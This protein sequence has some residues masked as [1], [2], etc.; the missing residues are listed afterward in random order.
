MAEPVVLAQV[1]LLLLT[2][3]MPLSTMV[4]LLFPAVRSHSP[5]HGGYATDSWV[6]GLWL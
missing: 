2:M 3:L 6:M 5:V 1:L 4:T